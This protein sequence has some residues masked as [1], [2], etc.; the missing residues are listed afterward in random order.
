MKSETAALLTSRGVRPTQQR[1]AVYEYLIS[2]PDHPS[3]ETVYEALV[4]EYPAFSKTTVYNSLY[5]LAEAGLVRTLTIQADELRFDGTMKT[6]GHI[7]CSRCGAV[8]DI[9][10]AEMALNSLCP[11]DYAFQRGDVFL[12]GLCSKCRG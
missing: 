6:H 7:Q 2:H 10:L 8:A 11:A 3:A 1:I 9:S 5:A 4:K 12:Y